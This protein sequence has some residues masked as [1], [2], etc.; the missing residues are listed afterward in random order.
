M[1]ITILLAIICGFNS[2]MAAIKITVIEFP[3]WYDI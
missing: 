3:I 1:N 2:Y